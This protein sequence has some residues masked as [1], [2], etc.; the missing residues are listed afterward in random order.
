LVNPEKKADRASVS[1]KKRTAR[2]PLIPDL[3]YSVS[4]GDDKKVYEI[5]PMERRFATRDYAVLRHARTSEAVGDVLKR[6]SRV[7]WLSIH[8]APTRPVREGRSYESSVEKKLEE[9]GNALTRLLSE[10][11]SRGESEIRVFEQSLFRSLLPRSNQW[12]LFNSVKNLDLGAEREGIGIGERVASP[13]LPQHR[14][15][16]S[17]YGVSAD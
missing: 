13:P 2:D 10:L 8:R 5:G 7:T 17:A 16:G 1:V 4:V 14:T 15:C 9:L 11:A 12:Q 3:L 6:L